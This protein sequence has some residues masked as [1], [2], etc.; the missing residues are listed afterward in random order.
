MA[1]LN[2]E[3]YI[4]QEQPEK[5]GA[6]PPNLPVATT[7]QSSPVPQPTNPPKSSGTTGSAGSNHK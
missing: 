1:E 3:R 6:V 2:K 5:Y 4:R 7:K